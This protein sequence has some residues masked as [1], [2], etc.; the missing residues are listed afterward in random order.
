VKWRRIWLKWSVL[1]I[2]AKGAEIAMGLKKQKK[3]I[4][5]PVK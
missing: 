4:V 3:G 5:A 2:A 1:L